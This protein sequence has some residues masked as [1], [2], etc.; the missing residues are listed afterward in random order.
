MLLLRI[1]ALL[2]SGYLN[3]AILPLLEACELF[4]QSWCAFVWVSLLP[5]PFHLGILT[6]FPKMFFP[7][8]L[9]GSLSGSPVYP[10]H[11][12]CV[13]LPSVLPL[14]SQELLLVPVS[15]ADL[16]V[17]RRYSSQA[18]TKLSFSSIDLFHE[19]SVCFGLLWR[20]HGRG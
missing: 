14:N 5:Y 3:V 11:C 9:F 8:L 6:L 16:R 1:R 12:S 18:F 10:T 7:S 17:L 15:F 4:C 2:I 19:S 13:G 20:D